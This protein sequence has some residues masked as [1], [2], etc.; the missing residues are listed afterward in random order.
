MAACAMRWCVQ[1]TA[2]FC[3]TAVDAAMGKKS[4][5]FACLELCLAPSV[6]QSASSSRRYQAKTRPTH[7]ASGSADAGRGTPARASR[8]L[9]NNLHFET[10][11]QDPAMHAV[12]ALGAIA[13]L[14][15]RDKGQKGRSRRPGYL[16]RRTTVASSRRRRRR[17]RNPVDNLRWTRKNS[18]SEGRCTVARRGR[19]ALKV[20]QTLDT[21]GFDR[22]L[23]KY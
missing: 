12:E 10:I 8:T 11:I 22:L 23:E 13:A 6:L 19:V 17:A 9:A 3:A 4:Q 18:A 16:T 7:A 14:K 5:A 1:A 15:N 2:S 21:K 20:R